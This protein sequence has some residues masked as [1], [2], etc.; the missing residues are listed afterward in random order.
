LS[1]LTVTCRSQQSRDDSR[2]LL[3]PLTLSANGA[4]FLVISAQVD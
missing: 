2:Q 3:L 1:T 4:S